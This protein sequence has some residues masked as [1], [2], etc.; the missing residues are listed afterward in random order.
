MVQ[1]NIRKI[2][3][4]FESGKPGIE[5]CSRV[6]PTASD[7]GDPASLAFVSVWSERRND[8]ADRLMNQRRRGMSSRGIVQSFRRLRDK[9]SEEQEE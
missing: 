3:P 2:G 1:K 9:R 6:F 7:Y 5:R 8:G 4:E